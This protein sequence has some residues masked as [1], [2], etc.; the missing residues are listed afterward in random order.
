MHRNITC[1]LIPGTRA[2]AQKLSQIAG[3]WKRTFADPKVGFPKF[4]ARMGDD[5]FTIPQAVKIRSDTI[6]GVYRLWIPKVGWC[7]LKRSG[8]NPYEG[9]LPVQAVIK[10]VLGRWYCTV[11]HDA[12]EIA[13]ADNGR[14][15][16]LDRNAG[17]VTASDGRIFKHPNVQVSRA[18]VTPMTRQRDMQGLAA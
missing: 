9:C 16:G 11:C 5:S 7:V 13:I 15:V 6:T 4:K 18:L 10:R 12:G 1:R 14:T 8:G 17:Q 2:K 3:A